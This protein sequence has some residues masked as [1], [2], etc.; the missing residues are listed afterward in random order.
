MKKVMTLGLVAIFSTLQADQQ[1]W[2]TANTFLRFETPYQSASPERLALFNTEDLREKHR[3]AHNG[4]VEFVIFGGQNSSQADAAAYYMPGGLETLT[5]NASID[6]NNSGSETISTYWSGSQG[7]IARYATIGNGQLGNNPSGNYGIGYATSAGNATAIALSTTA[8]TSSGTNSLAVIP[9][10]SSTVG[11]AL[12]NLAT[13]PATPT[14]ADQFVIGTGGTATYGTNTKT[15]DL[16][17]MR[18]I[19]SDSTTGGNLVN[20]GSMIVDTNKNIGIM[21]PWNF[22]VGYA[23]NVQFGVALSESAFVSAITPELKRSHWGIGATWKQLLSEKDTGFFLELSTALQ[24]VTMDMNL[25]EVVA[26][27]LV[28]NPTTNVDS[29][30][31][32]LWADTWATAEGFDTGDT[33]APTN[34][35]EAFAQAAWNYGRVDG[36]QSVTRLADIELKLGYQFICEDNLMSNMFVGIEFQQVTELN[37]YS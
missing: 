2:N 13:V 5:F 29:I 3:A 17:K 27:A 10:A 22:G 21:R 23:P 6:A 11:E 12:I 25:N 35:T 30:S 28:L 4:D 32:G 14:T 37:H 20:V 31:A 34:M 15:Q 26:E 24:R 8:G 16:T 1:N 19:L 33:V 36:A 7:G 18:A 9:T